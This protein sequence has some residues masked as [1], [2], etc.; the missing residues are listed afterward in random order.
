M[1]LLEQIKDGA[2]LKRENISF[3]ASAGGTGTV[4]LGSVYALLSIQTTEP[5][6]FRLYD[7][8]AS[9]DDGTESSRVFG[10][11][12][13]PDSIA[14][15]ADISMSVAGTY[16]IDPVLYGATED[17]LTKFSYYR[18]NPTGITPLITLKRFLL[19]DRNIVPNIQNSYSVDNRRTLPAISATLAYNELASGSI[20]NTDIPTTYLLIS[21]SLTTSNQIARLRLYN[22]SGSINNTNEKTRSFVT[23]ASASVGLIVDAVLNS[24]VVT[25]FVPKI[26]GSNI[27]N[28]GTN[29]QITRTNNEL[30]LGEKKL[31]YILENIEPGS[32]SE[33]MEVKLNVYSLEE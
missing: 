19:D 25:H 4:Q 21:A 33:A 32:P 11:T 8:E 10:D 29:L 18:I 23:E 16:T 6:R 14:L 31:Y 1:G 7:K 2:S 9:R 28:I 27:E 15:V 26:V 17:L 24:G 30:I 3:I 5:C 20:T 22:Q 12:N 13:I